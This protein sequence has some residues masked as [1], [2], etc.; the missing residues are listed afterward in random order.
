MEAPRSVRA[1]IQVFVQRLGP[2]VVALLDHGRAAPC[3]EQRQVR[4]SRR[5]AFDDRVVRVAQG[6]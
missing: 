6:S 2:L 1:V 3:E 5:V 4:V